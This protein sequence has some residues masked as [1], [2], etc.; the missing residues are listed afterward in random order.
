MYIYMGHMRARD[1]EPYERNFYARNAI[2]LVRDEVTRIDPERKTITCKTGGSLAYDYLV[3][4]LGSVSNKFGWPGQDLGGVQGMYSLQDLENIE[5]ATAAG[6]TRAVVVGGGLIGVEL[7]EMFHSRGV[8]VTFLV[9]EASYMDHAFPPEESALITREI[10]RHGIDLRTGTNLKA[11]L[12]GG[13]GRA[14]AVTTDA[15][16]EIAC[17]F[18]GLTAGVS[19]NL[20]LV[21]TTAIET[22][23]GIVVNDYLES[24]APGIFA[25]GDCAQFRDQTGFPGRVFPLWYTGKHQGEA[26]GKILAERITGRSGSFQAGPYTPGIWFN[27]AKFFNL[28]WQTYGLVSNQ[29]DPATT[30]YWQHDDRAIRL[31]WERRGGDTRITGFNLLGIRY[32]H[33]VCEQWLREERPIE[34][35]VDHLPEANFDPEFFPRYETEVRRQFREKFTPARI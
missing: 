2:E 27:S 33:A 13:R 25:A 35:V 32:R 9:R 10:L 3:L 11:I 26:L 8:P 24:S 1:T 6:I 18:V 5:A 16:A 14:R 23:R 20:G 29:R 15:G 19:P 17:Q 12:D 7:A 30:F 28:E 31:V 22:A 34:Y 4:A 21:K